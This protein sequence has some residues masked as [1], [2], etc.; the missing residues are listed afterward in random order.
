MNHVPQ[1]I[2]HMLISFKQA[3]V[4]KMAKEFQARI[5][6]LLAKI[7][8][9]SDI[10]TNLQ[11]SLVEYVQSVGQDFSQ[12]HRKLQDVFE[13]A[14]R[15]KYQSVAQL[16]KARR[17]LQAATDD[18]DHAYQ[19]RDAHE[20]VIDEMQLKARLDQDRITKIETYWKE[21]HDKL[22][23]RLTIQDEQL[24]G[25]RAL[26]LDSNPVSSAR[27]NAMNALQDPFNSPTEGSKAGGNMSNLGSPSLG[28]PLRNSFGPEATFGPQSSFG[29]QGSFGSQASFGT[30]AQYGPPPAFAPSKSNLSQQGLFDQQYGPHPTI[31]RRP[32][33]QTQRAMPTPDMAGPYCSDNSRCYNTEPGT[34]SG[35][36]SSSIPRVSIRKDLEHLSDNELAELFTAEFSK[37]FA[38]VEGFVKIYT[39]Q[40][41]LANDRRISSSN[42]TLWD[43]MLSCTYPGMRQDSHSHVMALL[44]D[45]RSRYWFCMR[46]VAAYLTINIINIEVFGQFGARQE[47][48]LRAIKTKLS[49]RGELGLGHYLYG[50]GVSY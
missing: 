37:I 2:L 50:Q 23:Q 46:I 13:R 12:Q 22:L 21:A 49:E 31:R 6:C 32:N 20:K 27:R 26:W 36:E 40:P 5:E 29:S 9:D 41:N 17:D 19:E 30:Q 43:F 7:R 1:F 25:K 39:S 24:R 15:E 11:A 4:V 47:V 3:N 28:S 10:P 48:E 14:V 45:A 33:L 42:Q 34:P 35:D 8:N 44:N 18:R 38:L 16:E